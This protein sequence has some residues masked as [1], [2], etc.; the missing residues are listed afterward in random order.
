MAGWIVGLETG[1][2]VEFLKYGVFEFVAKGSYADYTNVLVLGKGNGKANHH[3]YTG[4]LT[5]TIGASF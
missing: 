4:Q 1:F 2:R 5:A 3:F